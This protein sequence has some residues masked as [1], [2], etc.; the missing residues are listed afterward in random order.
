VSTVPASLLLALLMGAAQPVQ[1]HPTGDLHGDETLLA[2]GE[3]WLALLATPDGARLQQVSVK[4]DAVEDPL[5][6]AP[7]ERSGRRVS[8]PALSGDVLLRMSGGRLREG[9]V[10]R[11]QHGSVVDW[12]R[13]RLTIDLAGQASAQL[14]LSCDTAAAAAPQCELW[15]EQAG[16]RQRLVRHDALPGS[17]D[18]L[19]VGNDAPLAM[20]F[21]GDLDGDGRLDLILD[22]S[23]HYN[24]SQ[25]TLFLSGD[26]APGELLRAV[27]QHR[28]TGC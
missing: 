27:A 24:A 10:A 17:D 7:G 1:V 3:A 15:L 6:D 9:P 25:P 5:L 22:T 20:L 11:A 21:A 2:D 18:E 23:E 28:I 8:V 16:L 4:V 14:A 13:E 26:A 12:R 19:H